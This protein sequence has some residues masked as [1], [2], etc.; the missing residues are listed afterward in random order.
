M[1]LDT[2]CV[3]YLSTYLIPVANPCQS[4]GAS[5]LQP[6]FAGNSPVSVTQTE[7]QSALTSDT[8]VITSATSSEPQSGSETGSFDS[9]TG[10]LTD[11]ITTSS[12]SI[13]SSDALTTSTGIIESPGRPVIFLISAPNTYKRQNTDKVSS[14][15]TTHQSAPLLKVSTSLKSSSS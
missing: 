2:W 13:I 4:T 7:S 9:T 8:S 11:Q 10:T 1:N 14:E 6:T 3:T 5:S 12:G 15:T